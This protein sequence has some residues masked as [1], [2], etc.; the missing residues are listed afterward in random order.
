MSKPKRV[1]TPKL[2]KSIESTSVAWS[3]RK[4]AA[5]KPAAKKAAK[6]ASFTTV[7]ADPG[8]G[9]TGLKSKSGGLND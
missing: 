8:T 3:P 5:K 2:S 1:S 4:V 6:G 9:G 7:K